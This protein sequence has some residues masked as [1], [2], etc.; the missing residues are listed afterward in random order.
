[1]DQRLV[2]TEEVTDRLK[3]LWDE[4]HSASEIAAVIFHETQRLFTRNAVLGRVHR[5]GLAGRRKEP[6]NSRQRA[7][8]QPQPQPQHKTVVR[9]CGFGFAL[10]EFPVDPPDNP[11]EEP[12]AKHNCSLMQLTK[13]TCRWP[14]RG[15]GVET[16]FC[17]SQSVTGSPYCVSHC[18]LAY[19]TPRQKLTSERPSPITGQAA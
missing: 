4:G 10:R 6:L 17:G 13:N 12:V 5:L 19:T 8:S 2:W 1:M 18:G 9:R 14:V 15:E 3:V 16:V 7:K 11:R